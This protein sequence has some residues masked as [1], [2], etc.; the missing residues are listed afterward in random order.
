MGFFH[1]NSWMHTHKK[2]Y[3]EEN[4]NNWWNRSRKINGWTCV[5]GN[6]FSGILF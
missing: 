4:W 1:L 6:A 5:G 2:Y 3:F